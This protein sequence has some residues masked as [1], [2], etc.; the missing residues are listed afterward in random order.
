MHIEADNPAI[1][2]RIR[3]YFVNMAAGRSLARFPFGTAS[4]RERKNGRAREWKKERKRER[5]SETRGKGVA[6]T[7]TACGETARLA[8]DEV[9][10]DENT[11]SSMR[12]SVRASR[13]S[14]TF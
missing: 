11:F 4:T 12:R 6:R 3:E 8:K 2:G 7:K 14:E 9:R 5:G 1:A 13:R 10:R